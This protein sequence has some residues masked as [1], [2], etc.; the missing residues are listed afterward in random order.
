MT[1]GPGG[2]RDRQLPDGTIIWTSPTGHTYATY[3]GS[4][5]LF[6]CLS[7]PTAPLWE[8][9]PPTIEQV[10]ERGVMMPTRRH[11]RP[12][13]RPGHHRRTPTQRRPRR[14]TR[15]T[16]TVLWSAKLVCGRFDPVGA[17]GVCW[18]S[19][20]CCGTADGWWSC[21]GWGISVPRCWSPLASSPQLSWVGF[22][23]R[24][25]GRRPSA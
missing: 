1:W 7:T 23:F 3:T 12:R 5:L 25:P 11:T 20:N 15:Q 10:G 24:W 4:K 13:H 9:D 21:S 14:R 19:R 6:P 22:R 18:R 2:W 16:P 17:P 8:N